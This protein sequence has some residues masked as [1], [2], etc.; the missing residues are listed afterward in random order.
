[1]CRLAF[2]IF[3]QIIL[4]WNFAHAKTDVKIAV[5]S[6]KNKI[7]TIK[8]WKPL[9]DYLNE[10]VTGNRFTVIPMTHSEIENSINSHS[11]DFVF[12]NPSHYIFM[13]SYNHLTQAIA[14][15]VKD[16]NGNPVYSF[17]GVIFT[18]SERKDIN[19]V[20]DLKNKTLAAVKKDSALGG[21][22]IQAYELSKH[23]VDV[24]SDVSIT[25]TG[26]PQS[27]VVEKVLKGDADFGFVRTGM[28]EHM[29]KNKELDISKVKILNNKNLKTYPY[30]LSTSLYPEWPF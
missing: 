25:L 10:K 19:S 2:L 30:L 23:S 24:N 16:Y 18:L 17:G 5:L 12:T 20:K 26:L 28:L 15:V 3:L 29:V 7:Q 21:F 11:I 27:K 14:T 1:M 4:F 9:S 13:K 8:E 6:Y 22:Q